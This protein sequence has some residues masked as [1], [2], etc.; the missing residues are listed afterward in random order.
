MLSKYKRIHISY[1]IYHKLFQKEI[2]HSS[3]YLPNIYSI[4]DIS[5]GFLWPSRLHYSNRSS[6]T[7]IILQITSLFSFTQKNP[8]YMYKGSFLFYFIDFSGVLW[9]EIRNSVYD[10]IGNAEFIT[11]KFVGCF[12]PPKTKKQTIQSL[13][14]V[15]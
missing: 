13:N 15:F 7:L 10:R 2:Y 14:E 6:D 11:Y 9:N 8:R 1:F 12:I 3:S 4:Y 5:A